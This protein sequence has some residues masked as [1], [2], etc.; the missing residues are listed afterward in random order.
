ME[1]YANKS[2]KATGGN[3]DSQGNVKTRGGMP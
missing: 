1:M 3:G 2:P